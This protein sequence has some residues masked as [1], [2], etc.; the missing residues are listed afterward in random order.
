[1][2]QRFVADEFIEQAQRETGLTRFDSN[3]YREGL[4]VLVSDVNRDIARWPRSDELIERGKAR[5]VKCLADRLKSTDYLDKHPE[6]LR[7][8]I[9]RPLFVFGIPRTG[10][11]LLNN[12]LA[13]D[14]NRRS[15]L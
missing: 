5:I 9:E 15:A 4:E 1:M 14:P 12:L 7:R 3:S 11:T 2:A 8:P 10:T 13:A 6:L